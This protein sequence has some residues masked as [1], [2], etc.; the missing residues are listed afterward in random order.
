MAECA[1]RI[2][3]EKG[4]DSGLVNASG[5]LLAWGSPPSRD[6]WEISVADPRNR[7][8]DLLLLYL[9]QGAVISNE[10]LEN[11]LWT[12]NGYSQFIRSCADC[13]TDISK[14]VTLVCTDAVFGNAL[15]LGLCAMPLETGI[16]LVKDLN[17]IECAIIDAAEK[18][19]YSK[20]LRRETSA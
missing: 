14:H 18:V 7:S 2:L 20:N 1:K 9:Q 4:I 5:D 3:Q 12:G 15:A 19:H 11:N 16:A 13:S 8:L 6:D 17:G 10:R